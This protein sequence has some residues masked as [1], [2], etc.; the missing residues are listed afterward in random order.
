MLPSGATLTP[1][2]ALKASCFLDPI[3][4]EIAV[5]WPDVE[6]LWIRPFRVSATQ[7]VPSGATAIP[8]GLLRSPAGAVEP[9]PFF[10]Y[11]ASQVAVVS[12]A[13]KVKRSMRSLPE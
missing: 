11:V 7:T 9:T 4:I 2:G 8:V 5:Q 3:G 1:H 12:P 6:R 10:P 13:D